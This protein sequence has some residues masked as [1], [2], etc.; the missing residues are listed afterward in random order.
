MKSTQGVVDVHFP[1]VYKYHDA[2]EIFYRTHCYGNG[3]ELIQ[4]DFLEPI[5]RHLKRGMLLP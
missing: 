4:A 1:S 3:S 2:C 5:P